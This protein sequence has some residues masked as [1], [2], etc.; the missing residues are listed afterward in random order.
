MSEAEAKRVDGCATFYRTDKLKFVERYIIEYNALALRKEDFK[1]TEDIYN[2]VMTKDNVALVTVFERIPSGQLLIVANTHLHWDPAFKDVKVVQVALLL[3][4][5]ERIVGLYAS[6]STPE[7]S[8]Y[9]KYTDI[10]S[11]PLVI[12]GDFNSA[13]DSGVYQLFSQ[14]EVSAKHPDLEGRVYG[15]YTEDGISHKFNLRSAY[16]DVTSMPFTNYTPNF[17]EVIDYIWYSTSALT[18]TGAL[19]QIDPDYTKNF[20]GFPNPHH[21]S[22]HI[23]IVSQLS[24]KKVKDQVTHSK[25][26]FGN[27]SSRKT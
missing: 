11:I 26:N 19:G 15:R 1:K 23:P 10:K 20:V 18:V 14:G 8:K 22:D 9:P 17:V 12:C 21:P 2:R 27:S 3:E 4:E 16:A 6:N 24:F 25:P 13:W 5:L 7:G